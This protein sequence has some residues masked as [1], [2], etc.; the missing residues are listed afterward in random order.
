MVDEF[1]NRVYEN[2]N[3][4]HISHCK[5]V[6]Q[7]IGSCNATKNGRKE[8]LRVLRNRDATQE[9]QRHIGVSISVHET[10]LL[11]AQLCRNE[12]ELDKAR[13]FME[14]AETLKNELRGLW[15]QKEATGSPR[16]P[17]QH[18]QQPG[19]HPDD[20]QA[21]SRLLAH[22]AN[23][24]GKV[25]GREDAPA[26]W[27]L[28]DEGIPKVANGVPNRVHRLKGLGNAQCPLQAATAYR[29]LGGQ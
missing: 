19:E 15:L 11:L 2:I 22:G 21:M 4:N 8:V 24:D 5:I 17:E 26:N 13:V 16:R 27:W 10:A 6:N 7:L 1:P 23:K 18:Q 12:G 14:S 25:N 28:T 9:V 3:M 29:L 20:L